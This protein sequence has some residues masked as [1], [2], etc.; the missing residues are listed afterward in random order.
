MAVT[1]RSLA[2]GLGLPGST[3]AVQTRR[4]AEPLLLG[5]ALFSAA[6]AAIHFAVVHEHLDEYPAFGL[7]FIVMGWFQFAWAA[8]VVARPTRRLALAGAVGNGLI[9]GCWALSRTFGLPIGPEHWTP[10]A[11]GTA[12]VISTILEGLV[13]AGAIMFLSAST[14]ARIV[15]MRAV[16]AAIVTAAIV[17]ISL[18]SVA[19][20]APMESS[21]PAMMPVKAHRLT[22]V[23]STH[24]A[25]HKTRETKHR[26]AKHHVMK[27]R[28]MKHAKQHAM[29]HGKARK[30]CARS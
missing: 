19:L 18:T 6:S 20:A 9:M 28:F 10:E 29:K 22:C 21:G 16:R 3:T 25:Y 5:A 27:H 8:R 14:N 15:P 30:P 24:S 2:Q 12:D 23:G 17:A 13:V 11:V 1:T 7:A 4:L 26:V